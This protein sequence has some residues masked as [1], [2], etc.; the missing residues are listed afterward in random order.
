MLRHQ[1]RGLEEDCL[2]ANILIKL[3]EVS[4]LSWGFLL[5]PH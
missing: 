4:P 2:T 1:R 3:A 5:F